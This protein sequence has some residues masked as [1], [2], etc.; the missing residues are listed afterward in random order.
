MIY[1]LF[2]IRI[3][4][5]EFVVCYRVENEFFYVVFI[6]GIYISDL[7]VNKIG[8]GLVFLELIVLLEKCYCIV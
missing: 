2:S 6:Y 5:F 7:A 8:V 3:N 4:V 1:I